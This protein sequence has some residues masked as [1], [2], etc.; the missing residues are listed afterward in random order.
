MEPLKSLYYEHEEGLKTLFRKLEEEDLYYACSYPLLLSTWEANEIPKAIFFGQ[1]TNGWGESESIDILMEGYRK[2]DLGVNYPSLFW[3]YLRMLSE[4]LGL[5]GEHPF[6][7][8]NVNKFGNIDSKGRP[9][10]KVTLLENTYFNVMAKELE[11][12]KPEI[13]VF[14][15]G[16]NYDKDIKAKLN[17]VEFLPVLDYPINEFALVKSTYLPRHS[18]RIYHPG[19][20]NRFYDW[21]QDVLDTIAK[22]V[23]EL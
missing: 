12:L 17:D 11:V 13:C 22:L 16:P 1:E 7:W 15:T 19:Y 8:N 10:G 9:D 20:G 5:T 6:L 14:F 4:K 23:K 3:R 18:Y 21:Y 2:F